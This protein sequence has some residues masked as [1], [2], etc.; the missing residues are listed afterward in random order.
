MYYQTAEGTEGESDVDEVNQV[1]EESDEEMKNK[2]SEEMDES[3]IRKK[4]L[5]DFAVSTSQPAVKRIKKTPPV[6][7]I[8]PSNDPEKEIPSKKKKI[9]EID[10]NAFITL[11]TVVLQSSIPETEQGNEEDEEEANERQ[12]TLAEAFADDD[13][14][15]QFKEEKTR[16][17]SASVPSAIDLTLPGWGEWGGTGLKI[18][19]RKKKRFIIKP[20]PAPKRKDEN[21][22]NLILNEDKAPS[23][24][25]QQV[26]ELPHPFRSVSAFE[27]TIRAPVTSTFVPQTA[28]RK[29]TEPKVITKVGTVIQPMTEDVLISTAKPEADSDE[30]DEKKPAP[31]RGKQRN[32]RSNTAAARAQKSK[33]YNKPLKKK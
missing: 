1:D 18:S 26:S 13:V 31:V 24:R 14:V 2:F 20:P 28:V 23:L 6:Q 10:P 25:K 22:G 30:E 15:E 19:K 4:T 11:P 32:N 9:E 8:K 33:P 16:I 5:Q 3:L 29:L 12:M 7:S 21:Q 17:V 27:S